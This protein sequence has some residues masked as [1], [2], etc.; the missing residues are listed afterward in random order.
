MSETVCL[1]CGHLHTPD[2]CTGDPT[3][4]DL[5]AGVSVSGC[6][7]DFDFVRG[8]QM[9]TD[10]THE[11]ETL[12]EEHVIDREGMV[13]RIV[14][15][16]GM[17]TRAHQTG[18]VSIGIATLERESGPLVTL[19]AHTAAVEERARTQAWDEGYE[20]A[21]SDIEARSAPPGPNGPVDPTRNPYPA[22]GSAQVE[23][24][25]FDTSNDHDAVQTRR[26]RVVPQD[27]V[28]FVPFATA[29][30]T[31]DQCC[32]D[33]TLTGDREQHAECFHHGRPVEDLPR[34]QDV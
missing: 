10:N 7:C 12:A 27:P 1:D 5:W 17:A 3:P 23:A 32:I 28:Y 11:A 4:S 18:I 29:T 25:I 24:A 15:D 21:I 8:A 31:L 30:G 16:G 26:E 13:W 33:G 22:A 2:G 6:D 34:D 20:A 9:T 14:R 19:A